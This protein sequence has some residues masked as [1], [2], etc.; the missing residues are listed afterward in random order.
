MPEPVPCQPS[1]TGEFT[2]AARFTVSV[3]GANSSRPS[4]PSS[5]P[6][7]NVPCGRPLIAVTGVMAIITGL[8]TAL[9]GIVSENWL[10]AASVRLSV[11]PA[12]DTL[13]LT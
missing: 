10:P 7:A 6:A 3:A 8:S 13:A 5:T 12:V 2:G 9:A 1:G 11:P 4:G